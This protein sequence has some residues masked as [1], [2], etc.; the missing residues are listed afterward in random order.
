MKAGSNYWKRSNHF[1]LQKKFQYQIWKRQYQLPRWGTSRL[2]GNLITQE[3]HYRVDT[4]LAVLDAIIM[5]MDH[6][7]NEVSSELLVSFACLDPRD[8]FAR[9][10]VEKIA[11]LTDIYDQDFSIVDR[12][13]I[14]DQLETFIVHVK[15][16]D[17]FKSCHDLGRLATEMV[18]TKKHIT[19]P[20]IYRIIELALILPV[21]TSLVER[22]FSAMHLIKTA[23]RNKMGDEW[24]NN[25]LV[26]YVEKGIFKELGIDKVK[27]RFQSMKT[28]RV[29]L[30]KSPRRHQH[31]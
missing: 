12:D 20:L 1:V 31:S 10:D 5:E 26:C 21:A 13:S 15:R 9:F 25:L 2:D 14:R 18:A 8:N 6:R 29:S 19:F 7:F 3:H 30:P 28:R 27:K 11:R 16:I 4:F 17:D 24:L 23:L 22:A